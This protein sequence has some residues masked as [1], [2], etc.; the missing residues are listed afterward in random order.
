[1]SPQTI[2]ELDLAAIWKVIDRCLTCRLPA[3]QPNL[4]KFFLRFRM[5]CG[6][7]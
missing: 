3:N 6:P 2:R 5:E 4:D 7:V 1:M